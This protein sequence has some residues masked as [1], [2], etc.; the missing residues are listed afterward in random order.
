[1]FCVK[2]MSCRLASSKRS[3]YHSSTWIT[4]SGLLNFCKPRWTKKTLTRKNRPNVDMWT[5]CKWNAQ[6]KTTNLVCIAVHGF[7]KWLKSTFSCFV[8]AHNQQ[9]R[10][11]PSWLLNGSWVWSLLFLGLRKLPPFSQHQPYPRS[12]RMHALKNW[13]NAGTLPPKL[14]FQMDSAKYNKSTQCIAF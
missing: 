8:N 11:K 9:L 1:M 2:K 12:D 13:G 5:T 14:Y 3:E 6:T 4:W 7:D 10:F